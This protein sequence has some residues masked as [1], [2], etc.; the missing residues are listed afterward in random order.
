MIFPKKSP[1]GKMPGSDF[2][3]MRSIFLTALLALLVRNA[4]GRLAGGLAG[5][6][7]LAAAAVTDAV[8]QVAGLQSL[9][10]IH[11]HAS[12]VTDVSRAKGRPLFP[13]EP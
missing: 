3:V 1:L 9:D 10:V 4:A 8:G 2:L 5:S 11:G 13:I 12:L 6:L 7:A